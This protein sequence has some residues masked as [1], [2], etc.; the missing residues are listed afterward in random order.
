[1]KVLGEGGYTISDR[2]KIDGEG[3][4][5]FVFGRGWL[6]EVVEI[7]SGDYYFLSDGKKVR[8]AGRH[9]G[10]FYPP[11]SMVRPAVRNVRGTV[12]GVGSVRPPVGL[13]DHPVLFE[14]DRRDEFTYVAEAAG[15][16]ASARGIS[17]IAINT[18]PSPVSL[19][20]K[21]L[22]DENYLAEPAIARIAERLG[23]SHEHM[24]RQF[25]RDFGMA[26]S[27][28]LHQL[29]VAEAT[30]RLS[31]GEEI[32]DISGEVGYNDLSRFYKQSKKKTATSPAQ[33]RLMFDDAEARA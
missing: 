12:V 23:I 32:I 29:R 19:G 22:I 11:F 9:F 10:V 18:R 2:L 3:A 15:V 33:C 20:C 13:P 16:L 24:T 5:V 7:E 27:A 14:T 30:F 8:P 31:L 6:L 1:M 17:S 26:P 28:Y 21:K 25:K 4:S